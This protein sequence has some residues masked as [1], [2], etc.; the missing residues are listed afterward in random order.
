[1]SDGEDDLFV[2][3][4]SYD[5]DKA[6]FQILFAVMPAYKS[7]YKL[8]AYRLINELP[9]FFS[10]PNKENKRRFRCRPVLFSC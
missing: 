4:D 6:G 1:M 9:V 7:A 8:Y 5:P 10:K 2:H 3:D